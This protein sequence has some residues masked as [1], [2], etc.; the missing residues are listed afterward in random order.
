MDG[1]EVPQSSRSGL[2]RG[3]LMD[4]GPKQL[5]REVFLAL[6]R[7]GRTRRARAPKEAGRGVAAIVGY[8]TSRPVRSFSA[9]GGYLP[10]GPSLRRLARSVV[11]A[12]S[13]HRS[14]ASGRESHPAGDRPLPPRPA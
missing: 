12:S 13:I 6:K 3:L 5:G 7:C 1:W 2:D 14:T 8:F 10:A 9:G 4:G 11:V